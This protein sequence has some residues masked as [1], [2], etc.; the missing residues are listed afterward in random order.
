MR[1]AS[2]RDAVDAALGQRSPLLF[3]L[4]GWYL[5]WYFY[6][7]FHAVRIARDGLPPDV[8]GRPLILYSNHPSWWDPAVHILLAAKLFPGRTGY[9]PIDNKALAQYGLLAKMGAFGV[10]QDERGGAVFLRTSLAVLARPATFLS[11]TAEGRFTDHRVRPVTLRPGLAHVARRVPGAVILPLALEYSFWNESKAEVLMRFGA[12]VLPP[13]SD[14]V[15]VWNAQLEAALTATMDALAA[16]S[17]TRN[18]G[19]FQP[20]LRGNAGVGGVYDLWRRLRAVM[21]GQPFDPSHEGEP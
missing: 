19:L 5:R 10:P 9:G 14:D 20:L 21:A 13:Q 12:P 8:G 18:A 2:A 17:A 11:I 4:F 16:Q 15:A 7:S 1:H 3:W 6:R